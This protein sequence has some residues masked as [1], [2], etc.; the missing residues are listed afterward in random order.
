M[1]E[2]AMGPV[3]GPLMRARLHIRSGRARLF[4]GAGLQ[5]EGIVILYDALNSALLHWAAKSGG[6]LARL[7]D[8]KDIYAALVRSEVLDG[9]FSYER[10]EQT[11][12]RAL[13]GWT[14]SGDFLEELWRGL[15]RVFTRLGVMPF[16]EGALPPEKPEIFLKKPDG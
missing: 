15:E 4:G 2:S 6:E 10:F 12:E 14:G 13:E 1:D 5:D 7:K 9:K 3:E 11:V 8:E 16:D